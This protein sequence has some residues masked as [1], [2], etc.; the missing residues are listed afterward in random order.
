MFKTMKTRS[1]IRRRV[2]V[3]T[4]PARNHANTVTGP[5]PIASRPSTAVLERGPSQSRVVS[6]EQPIE[7]THLAERSHSQD[8]AARMTDS[9]SPSVSTSGGDASAIFVGIDVAKSKLDLART[10]S[11]E[12]FTVTNDAAGIRRILDLL[13]PIHPTLVVIEATGGLERV[14]LGELL[15]ADLPVAL[16]NP[17]QVRHFAKGIGILAKTDAVDARVLA[18]YAKLASP[19][20][21]EKRS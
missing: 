19:R 13:R 14:A 11:S 17:G 8:R 16:A 15:D 4:K 7:L 20:L 10:D 6:P 9:T 18:Q 5:R 21:T 2:R 3:A 1:T 12:I